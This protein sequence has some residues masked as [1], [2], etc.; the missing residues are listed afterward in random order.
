[1]LLEKLG[2][3]PVFGALPLGDVQALPE[4]IYLGLPVGAFLLPFLPIS[5]PEP[6]VLVRRAPSLRLFLVE[7]SLCQL[8]LL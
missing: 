2:L 6:A 1:L 8:E 4:A 7:V 5:L 3:T